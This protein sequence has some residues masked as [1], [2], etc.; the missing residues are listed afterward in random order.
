MMS[1]VKPLQIPLFQNKNAV[2]FLFLVLLS[3]KKSSDPILKRIQT[4][5]KKMR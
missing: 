4:M 5:L 2:P 3:Q 1:T